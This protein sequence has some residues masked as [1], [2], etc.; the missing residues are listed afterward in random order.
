MCIFQFNSTC[1]TCFTNNV[2][3]RLTSSSLNYFCISLK[4][5]FDVLF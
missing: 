2:L 1:Q 4:D 5:A 3:R